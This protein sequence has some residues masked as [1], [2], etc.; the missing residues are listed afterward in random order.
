M[1]TNDGTAQGAEGQ[2]AQGAQGTQEPQTEQELAKAKEDFAKDFWGDAPSLPDNEGKGEEEES[3]KGTQGTGE[4]TQAGNEGK[5]EGS[6]GG[7][8]TGAGN[9]GKGSREGKGEGE[10]DQ[11]TSQNQS[12]EENINAFESYMKKFNPDYK[13]PDEVKNKEGLTNEDLFSTFEAE[14]I[15]EKEKDPFVK[16]YLLRK[17]EENF[18]MDDYLNENKEVTEILRTEDNREFLK[19]IYKKNGEV[20][21]KEYTDEQIEEHLNTLSAIQI[22]EQADHNRARLQKNLNDYYAKQN[23]VIEQKQVDEL[24]KVNE[25]NKNT[26]SKYIEDVKAKKRNLSVDMDEKEF[27]NFVKDAPNLI[28]IDPSTGSN[29]VSDLLNSDD[30]FMDI[31]P[32]IYKRYQGSL[33]DYNSEQKQ[34]VKDSIKRNLRPGVNQQSRSAGKNLNEETTA[35]NFFD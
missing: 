2:E 25:T 21:G 28:D 22:D 30:F 35:A 23:Q 6:D 11:G 34:K 24:K 17:D 31:L 18:S 10:G 16:N 29:I 12:V 5:G 33:K 13:V 4:G 19:K 8:G 9:E 1:V 3:G 26:I 7:E 32:Y 15:K 14:V 27:E 20:R